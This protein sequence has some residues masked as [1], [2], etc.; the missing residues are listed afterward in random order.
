MKISAQVVCFENFLEFYSKRI[1]PQFCDIDI[2]LKSGEDMEP[3]IVARLLSITEQELYNIMISKNIDFI[4]KE[5]FLKIM[6]AGSSYICQLY[7]REVEC[8]C[9]NSYTA[10][11]ISYIYS[12]DQ[13]TIET[14]C[15]QMGYGTYISPYL[16]K[17][18]FSRIQLMVD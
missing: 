11:Q 6:L 15:N 9:P 14:I 10:E 18:I 4:T 8:N 3:T 2:Y 12:L 16:L 1:S 5:N 7:R 17:D 13:Q